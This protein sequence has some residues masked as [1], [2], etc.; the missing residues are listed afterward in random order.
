MLLDHGGSGTSE[1]HLVRLVEWTICID[2]QPHSIRRIEFSGAL[3]HFVWL[4]ERSGLVGNSRPSFYIMH[5]V[6]V[7]SSVLVLQGNPEIFG[8]G[9][10]SGL[11]YRGQKPFSRKLIA[12]VKMAT[13]AD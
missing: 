11:S 2:A 5:L 13:H 3:C 7:L 6:V 1:T 4:P 12:W 10:A 9:Y 8:L